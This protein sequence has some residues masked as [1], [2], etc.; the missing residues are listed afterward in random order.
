MFDWLNQIY[1]NAM[2]NMDRRVGSYGDSE[3]QWGI[4]LSILAAVLAGWAILSLMR[5][6]SSKNKDEE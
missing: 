4:I 1:E 2:A 5:K 6:G 3:V